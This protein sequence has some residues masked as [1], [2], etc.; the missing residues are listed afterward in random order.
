M[1]MPYLV[2]LNAVPISRDD[3][4]IF[5]VSVGSLRGWVGRV[6]TTSKISWVFLRL[7]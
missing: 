1:P 2:K 3:L 6:A 4:L 7:R 5:E